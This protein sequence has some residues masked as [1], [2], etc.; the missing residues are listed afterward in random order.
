V[1]VTKRGA[2]GSAYPRN[3]AARKRRPW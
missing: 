3:P 2:T 1:I